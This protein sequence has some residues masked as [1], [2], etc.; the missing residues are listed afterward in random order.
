[1]RQFFIQLRVYR[2]K[3]Q[4]YWTLMLLVHTN[5]LASLE[6]VVA[7]LEVGLKV[8]GAASVS[9]EQVYFD[10]P[11]GA[12]SADHYK[13]LTDPYLI[14]ELKIFLG[15]KRDRRKREEPAIT[16]ENGDQS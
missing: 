15:L 14:D 1:M 8:A 11:V 5:S 10:Y 4:H 12:L 2:A 16:T 9:L 3:D 6:S 7:G 13:E